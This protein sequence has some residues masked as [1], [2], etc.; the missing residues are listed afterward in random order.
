ML[1]LCLKAVHVI[2]VI[3]WFSALFYLPRLFV[4]HADATDETSDARFKIMERRL[5]KLMS[6]AAALSVTAGTSLIWL[7]PAWLR[8]GWLQG[9]L[10]LVIGLVVYH[11][12]C[13]RLL[14]GFRDGRNRHSAKWY[15]WFNEIPALLLVGIVVLAILKPA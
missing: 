8:Q 11:I 14:S 15:R 4:Y 2:F 12:W 1:Y 13:G 5:Y 3:S 6:L 9:K 7:E 10:V